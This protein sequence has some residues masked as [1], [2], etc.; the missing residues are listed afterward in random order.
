VATYDSGGTVGET[1]TG[2]VDPSAEVATGMD[3]SGASSPPQ[4]LMTLATTTAA[5][6]PPAA[7]IGTQRATLFGGEDV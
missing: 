7:P 3:A 5:S 1:D 4:P 6:R 2:T